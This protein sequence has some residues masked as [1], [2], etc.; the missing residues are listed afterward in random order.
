MDLKYSYTVTIMAP[1]GMTV[2]KRIVRPVYKDLIPP[3]CSIPRNELLLPPVALLNCCCVFITSNGCVHT[4]A[5]KPE[6]E[7]DKK[8]AVLLVMIGQPKHVMS[9]PSSRLLLAFE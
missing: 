5:M 2:L 4:A 8:V 3:F 6:M 7:P 9:V 1:P